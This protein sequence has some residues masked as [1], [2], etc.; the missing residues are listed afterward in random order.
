M[1]S[2]CIGLFGSKQNW[3]SIGKAIHSKTKPTRK[4][5][6]QKY[7]FLKI[8]IYK[9]NALKVIAVDARNH[10]ESPHSAHHRYVDLAED[11]KLFYKEHNISKAV[12]IGHSMG[13]MLVFEE[14]L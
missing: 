8:F 2:I 5:C 10:G 13:G 1:F 7:L 11:I 4:V 12:V 6:V 9:V 14:F 3:R